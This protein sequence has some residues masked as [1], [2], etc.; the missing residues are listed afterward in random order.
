M[1]EVTTILFRNAMASIASSVSIIT[2]DGPSG[3]YGITVSSLS[4][5]TDTPPTLLTCVKRGGIANSIFKMNK[6]VCVNV[7]SAS[8]ESVA[9]QYARGQEYQQSFDADIWSFPE[10]KPPEL[11]NAV[12][13][14]QGYIENTVECGTHSV[15]FIRMEHIVVQDNPT[16]LVHFNRKFI[17]L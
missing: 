12:T 13:V 16:A 2:T 10:G 11:N 9:L 1:S 15:F 7:L 3:C 8:H 4:S 5:V 14:I 6:Q 17:P